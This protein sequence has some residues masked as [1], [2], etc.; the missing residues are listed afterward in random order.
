MHIEFLRDFLDGFQSFNGFKGYASFEVRVVSAAFG[1]HSSTLRLRFLPAFPPPRYSLTAGPIFGGHLTT[2]VEKGSIEH[3]A[4]G[5]YL[6]SIASEMDADLLGRYFVA[7]D[8]SYRVCQKIRQQ[9]VFARQNVLRDPPFTKVDLISCRNLLI[10]LRTAAQQKVMALFH[11]AL[12]PG[13]YL[14]LGTSEAIGEQEHAFNTVSAKMRIFQKRIDSTVAI[15]GAVVGSPISQGLIPAPIERAPRELPASA[16]RDH[17]RIW[18][19]I[20]ARLMAEL[21]MTCFVVD[22]S[23]QVLH[24]FG[25][26]QRFL[27]IRSGGASLS[28]LRLVDRPLSLAL[29]KALRHAEKQS[30][31]VGNSCG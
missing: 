30:R 26:P 17:E 9:I 23:Y 4:R 5:V 27:K 20:S 2:D 25:D 12:R 1:F 6:K 10:Y 21:R 16:R 18:E 29:S 7:E 19:T 3:A 22:G 24:T 15:S 14:L 31:A 11:F 28:I 13:G 8:E